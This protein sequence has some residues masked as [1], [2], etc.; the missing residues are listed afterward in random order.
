MSNPRPVI[1]VDAMGGDYGP[2]SIV[3]GAMGAL[4]SP[5]PFDLVFYG[6]EPA[7]AAELEKLGADGRSV[8]VVHCTQDIGMGEAP[9][10]AI[11]FCRPS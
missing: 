2:G 5:S 10:A 1:A 6:D 4:A 3:P 9:S 8:S 7:V 11:R